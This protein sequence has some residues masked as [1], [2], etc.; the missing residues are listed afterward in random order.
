LITVT[1]YYRQNDPKC[2]AVEQ[3]LYQ[4][5]TEI[6]H[7]L[8]LVDI[9][10]ETG[11]TDRLSKAV[12]VVK[13][14]PYTI[15]GDF[16]LEGLRVT[17]G[18]AQDR[19]TR[20]Q[21]LDD[22][23]FKARYERARTFTG[24]DRLTDWLSHHYLALFNFFLFLYAG[25]PFLAPVLMKTGLTLPARVIYTVYS[26]LCHQMAFRSWFLF[27][28]QPYYPRDLA[29]MSGVLSYEAV[30]LVGQN[31]PETSPDFIIGARNFFGDE[32]VGY[33]VALCQ[34][35]VALYGGML[36][37][38]LIFA[39][40]GRRIGQIPWYFWLIFGLIPIGIDGLS[41]FPGLIAGLP[42]WLPVRE[43]TPLWRT[44]TG[45]LFGGLTAWYLYPLIE[46][47]MKDTRALLVSKKQVIVQTRSS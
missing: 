14:G 16:T 20:L 9:D 10:I 19:M 22:P 47:T 27:G 25:L 39:L 44:L 24:M 8:V 40:S 2:V 6:P 36:L 23:K 12:P 5:Q 4:I 7:Q 35:D 33:K 38:G 21:E 3:L 15:Q 13:A 29:G 1:F 31:I 45:A 42:D 26:P 30:I 32:T 41:Q 37:F 18:A 28:E 17:L 11:L 43:S 46:E 34:R